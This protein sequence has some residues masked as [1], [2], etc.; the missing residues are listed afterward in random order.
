MAASVSR[1]QLAA[2]DRDGYLVLGRTLSPAQ[3]LEI[4][5]EACRSW[6]AAGGAP[7]VHRTSPAI[8]AFYWSGPLV[9]VAT[10]LIGPN[11]K[12]VASQLTYQLVGNTRPFG[13]HQDNGYGE[14]DP[15]NA[16][17]TLTALDDTDEENGCLWVIPR[18]HT[19]RGQ[20]AVRNDGLATAERNA[21]GGEVV[22]EDVDE[23]EAVAVPLR[24]GETLLLHCHTLHRSKGNVSE[25]RDRRLLFLRY[26]DA[27][28]VE[29]YRPAC[30]PR[31]G[32]L[33][34]GV[35]VFPSVEEYEAGD[36][37]AVARRLEFAPAPHLPSR[38]V[39]ELKLGAKVALVNFAARATFGL[40]VRRSGASLAAQ[41][42]AWGNDSVSLAYTLLAFRGSRT[43][44][45]GA[46]SALLNQVPRDGGWAE[47]ARAR[48]RPDSFV[49]RGSTALATLLAAP[50]LWRDSVNSWRRVVT[51]AVVTRGFG[52]IVDKST[53]LFAAASAQL[54]YAFILEPTSLHPSTLR[55][56]MRQ[57]GVHPAAHAL[58][59]ARASRTRYWDSVPADVAAAALA[60]VRRQQ[61][62]GQGQGQGGG[63][64]RRVVAAHPHS[65]PL[66]APC[67]ELNRAAVVAASSLQR[68]AAVAATTPT[69]LAT[70]SSS[71]LSS[72]VH[73]QRAG[74]L[75]KSDEAR[76]PSFRAL[77]LPQTSSRLNA[78]LRGAML[79][80]A[81]AFPKALRYY[82]IPHLAMFAIR[83]FGRLRKQKRNNDEDRVLPITRTSTST[84]TSTSSEADSSNSSAV[85]KLMVRIVRS[86]LFLSVYTLGVQWLPEM[87]RSVVAKEAMDPPAWTFPLAGS[88]GSLAASAVE[89]ESTVGELSLWLG[90][91]AA[92]SATRI[93]ARRVAGTSI[94]RA[95]G[96]TSVLRLEWEVSLSCSW[97]KIH[98]RGIFLFVSYIHTF[99]YLFIPHVLYLL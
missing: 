80:F 32:R 10:Q 73:Q 47:S 74:K 30:P 86:A 21:K 58:I 39:G 82:A 15:Y 67:G 87:I 42:R 31:L 65:A 54:C 94:A 90:A 23:R 18:S 17:S 61:G 89:L 36:A 8:R 46:C 93:V 3:L 16:V 34:R 81:R 9:D 37:E 11:V 98:F 78:P 60:L 75:S 84:S 56:F 55:L 49:R 92:A 57:S 88:L 1:A 35:T 40:A 14:L 59:H 12:A 29:R 26:A 13:W 50:L 51:L 76:L 95:A 20:I 25:V 45:E 62:Q 24:A 77:V 22:L 69:M 27:N 44:L 43:L 71:S 70:P 41:F 66:F 5:V 53:L 85:K 91:R 63:G 38:A 79:L 7:D 33:L 96:L 97:G 2:Y 68:V 99:S 28:A 4:Q 72:R 6:R 52:A 64:A 19:T 48:L 83:H